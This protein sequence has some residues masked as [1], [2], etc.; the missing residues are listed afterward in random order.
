MAGLSPIGSDWQTV[1]AAL[2]SLTNGVRTFD[3]WQAYSGLNC[4]LGAPVLDFETP[5]HYPRKMRRAMG[6]VSL[7]SVRA[8]ELALADAGLTDD[9]VLGGGRTGV[10]YGSSVGSPQSIMEFGRLLTEHSTA[11][12]TANSYIKMMPHTTT[13]AIGMFFGLTGRMLPSS[14]ACTSGSLSIGLGYEMI[15]YG[16][17][18]LMIAG[19]AEELNIADVAAFDTLY[20][21]STANDTPGRTPRPFDEDRDG[22]VVGEGAGTLILEDME[23]AAARG[24]PILAEVVGFGTNSDGKH[25]TQPTRETMAHAMRL[26]LE[27]ADLE[28]RDIGYVSAHGT[29]TELGDIA[30]TQATAEVLGPAPISSLKSYMGHT[31]GACGSLEAWMTIRMLSEGWAAPTIN[32]QQVDQRCGELDYLTDAIQPLKCRYF[33]TNNFAFGGVNTS[34]IFRLT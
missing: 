33:M 7:L 16:L 34:I 30:E 3:E 27:D 31:L 2:R 18:D 19:G 14:T 29:A 15:R 6:R 17:Q 11:S 21:T 4:R 10:S 8:T 32:L 20:A 12:I 5:D 22:L 23:R 13:A 25:P 24:A 28:P 9:P 26:A 1:A